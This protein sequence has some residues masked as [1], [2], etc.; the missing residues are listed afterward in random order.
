M[1]QWENVLTWLF[2]PDGTQTNDAKNPWELFTPNVFWAM[3]G[4]H[5]FPFRAFELA[6]G[7][8]EICL[9]FLL[10]QLNEIMTS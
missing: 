1:H 8:H 10:S 4:A 5:Y 3:I 9:E 7:D 2:V 6:R